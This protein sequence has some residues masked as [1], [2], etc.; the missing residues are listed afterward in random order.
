MLLTGYLLVDLYLSTTVEPTLKREKS[1]I[2][3]KELLWLE[4]GL[5]STP[6]KV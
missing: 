6:S 5:G 4:A 1:R 2:F 3:D